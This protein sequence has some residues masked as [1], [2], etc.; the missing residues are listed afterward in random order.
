MV[1]SRKY[2]FDEAV[3]HSQ[4]VPFGNGIL[5][6]CA[7]LPFDHCRAMAWANSHIY[8]FQWESTRDSPCSWNVD[9][10]QLMPRISNVHTYSANKCLL[11]RSVACC[12]SFITYQ[13]T[14]PLDDNSLVYGEAVINYHYVGAGLFL[15]RR[16]CRLSFLVLVIVKCSP[17][18]SLYN[19]CNRHRHIYLFMQR[20]TFN[21]YKHNS[22][23]LWHS[24]PVDTIPIWI[25]IGEVF[26]FRLWKSFIKG[27]KKAIFLPH[28]QRNFRW[29]ILLR[30][31][32]KWLRLSCHRII[33]RA[34]IQ[35]VNA[36]R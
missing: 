27:N 15:R 18:T 26:L 10:E 25:C 7:P 30:S 20:H 14:K 12:F 4:M 17:L 16:R 21:G 23:C 36:A 11:V 28:P 34:I 31:I 33:Y 5:P 19:A 9:K 32:W 1:Q 29:I 8:G 3:A 2:V 13:H 24:L 6:F 35:I 22:S